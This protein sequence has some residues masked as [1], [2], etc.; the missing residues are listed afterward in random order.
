MLDY[1]SILL[2]ILGQI[3]QSMTDTSVAAY[4]SLDT[5]SQDGCR[6]D[7]D[8]PPN[9]YC[10]P[11]SSGG[12]SFLSRFKPKT[13]EYIVDGKCVLK[14]ISYTDQDFK[15]LVLSFSLH[16]KIKN[17]GIVVFFY[18]RCRGFCKRLVTSCSIHW[19]QA[20]AWQTIQ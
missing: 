8:C 18:F 12:R 16:F 17:E 19:I 10:Q 15:N 5:I 4:R 11:S 9:H 3:H 20:Q 7:A 13:F 2:Y 1:I 6:N 14:G